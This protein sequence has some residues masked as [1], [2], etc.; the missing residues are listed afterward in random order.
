MH[1]LNKIVIPRIR[2][3]WRDVAYSMGYSDE[4]DAIQEE[5]HHDLK[6][7]CQKLFTDWLKTSHYRTWGNL[8]KCIKDV[9]DLSAA[10][11]EIEKSLQA[12]GKIIYDI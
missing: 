11:E 6:R 4:V 10:A 1:L 8:L 3:N 7:C 2:A 5:S 12:L 9:D